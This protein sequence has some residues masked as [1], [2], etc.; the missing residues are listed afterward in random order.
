[1]TTP[2]ELR[3]QSDDLHA[4]YRRNF[5]GLP[6]ITRDAQLLRDI[7]KQTLALRDAAPEGAS[8]LQ[9]TLRARAALYAKELESIEHEQSRGP[10]A[11]AAARVAGDANAAFDRYRRH[12]GGKERWSRDLGMLQEI[13]DDL[14]MAE[15][16]F[17]LV[18]ESFDDPSVKR[19]LGIVQKNLE[20]Y[21]EEQ[22]AIQ[23]SKENLDEEQTISSTA[24]SANTLFDIYRRQFGGLPRL[25]RRPELLERMVAQLQVIESTMESAIAKGNKNEHLAGNIAL[26]RDQLQRWENELPEIRNQRATVELKDLIMALGTEVDSVWDV[27]GSEY[28]GQPRE[29]R[30]LEQLSA[31]IDRADEV[32]RQAKDLHREYDLA[33]TD[34]L[35]RIS[36]DQRLTLMRE[37]TQ[38]QDAIQARTVH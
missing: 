22:K 36:R 8:E 4:E 5:G 13:I 33:A 1:M 10:F 16:N 14:T 2:T 19:D 26:V 24:G 7:R 9:E 35:L 37:Y 15:K 20:L 11:M 25:S 29:T 34:R 3:Q 28:A 17:K 30:D 31:L 32:V 6:R 18:L 27:W 12:F 38:I 21:R 23:E